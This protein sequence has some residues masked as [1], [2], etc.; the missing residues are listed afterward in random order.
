MRLVQLGRCG[1]H[2]SELC[3][4]TMTFGA[5]ADAE[6]SA[7]LYRRCREAGITT[8]DCADVYAGGESERILGGL[9]AGERDEVVITSKVGMAGGKGPNHQGL[10][11]RWITT[12][13]ERSLA[14]LG[15]DRIDVYFVHRFDPA[16]P[17]EESLRALDDLVRAGKVLHLGVSNFA[18]WQVATALGISAL[19]DWAGFDVLQPMYNLVKRQAEVEL[20]PLAAHHGLGVLSY[21]PLGGGLLSGKYG[22]NAAAAD[23]RLRANQRYA[24]RYGEDWMHA[25]ATGFTAVAA[26]LGQHPVS[27]AVA[28]VARHP[29]ITAPLIGA[30]NLDQLEPALAAAGLPIDDECYARLC[31]LSPTPP[32]ATDRNEE[33]S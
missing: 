2:V 10:S 3:F 13:C 31:A 20:L 26:E 28:W 14:A 6:M 29:A 9:I 1:L 11:R 18:A 19:H 32:S 12:R 23:S 24:T 21:S 25:A 4:G 30:R 5:Q 33:R 22:T 27:L 16:T 17:L 7:A 8:F 15:T